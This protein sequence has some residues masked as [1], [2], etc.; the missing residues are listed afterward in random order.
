MKHKIQE[1]RDNYKRYNMYITGLPEKKGTG[2]IFEAIM[3]ESS[4][5]VNEKPNHG[6]RKPSEQ[7]VR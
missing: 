1:L 3:V 7:Q 4:P 5:S 2:E 6:F